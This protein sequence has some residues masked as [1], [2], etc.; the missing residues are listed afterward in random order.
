MQ[1]NSGKWTLPSLP[2]AISWCKD[3]NSQ[4][5]SC[6]I[7]YLGGIPENEKLSET[8]LD[9]YLD[10]VKQIDEQELDSSVTVKLTLLGALSNKIRSLQDALAISRAAKKRNLILEIATESKNLVPY[11]LQTAAACAERKTLVILD[12][13]AYLDQTEQ[14]LVVALKSGVKARIV[15]GAYAG[16]ISGQTQIQRRFKNLVET[17]LKES[18]EVFLGTHDS[19]LVN[20]ARNEFSDRKQAIEFGFLKGLSD[21]TKVEL[22]DQ[23]WRVLEYVPFG[24]KIQSYEARRLKFMRD[25]EKIGEVIA[26]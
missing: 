1:Y 7:G 20:W 8:A 6:T 16:D 25:S 10:I 14:D 11:V 18:G 3:R 2:E 9:I 4:G 17:S 21:E 15:K 23:G 22:A 13:Q 24:S 12:L 26:P 19:E 5:I